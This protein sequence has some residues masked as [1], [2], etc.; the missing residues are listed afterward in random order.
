MAIGA[1]RWQAA[2]GNWMNRQL[3]ALPNSLPTTSEEPLHSR[4]VAP[5]EPPTGHKI[6]VKSN[7][8]ARSPSG[9]SGVAGARFY[10]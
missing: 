6:G 5:L 2:H 3:T 10:R 8:L 9:A 7:F 1:P 4:V